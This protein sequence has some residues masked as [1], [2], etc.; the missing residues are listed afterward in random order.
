[1]FALTW[2][3]CRSFVVVGEITFPSASDQGPPCY[4]AL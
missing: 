1:L 2:R 4:P 3:G